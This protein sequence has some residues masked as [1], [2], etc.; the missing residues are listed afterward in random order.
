MYFL[1][2]QTTSPQAIALGVA[3][4]AVGAAT[5]LIGVLVLL[6]RFVRYGVE[7]VRPRTGIE[8]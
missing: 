4:F 6:L 7:A 1:R 2:D 5:A 3:F 8:E